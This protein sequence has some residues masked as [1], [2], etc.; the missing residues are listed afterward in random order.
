MRARSVVAIALVAIPIAIIAAFF[1]VGPERLW[2][3]AGPAD[4]G[5]VDFETL[6]RRETP[7][8]ALACPPGACKARSDIKP[9]VFAVSAHELRKAFRTAVASEPNLELV[10]VDENKL[11]ARYVQRSAFWRFP[12]T[13]EVRFVDVEDGRSTIAIYSRSL[14]GRGDLGVNKARVQRWIDKLAKLAPVVQIA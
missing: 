12:D 13:I 8:D 3:L 14:V 5:P 7:N 9:P 4:Q 2:S 11:T 6:S 1:I 10:D